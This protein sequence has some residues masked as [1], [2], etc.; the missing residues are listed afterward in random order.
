MH[1][2]L[3]TVT[4]SLQPL[5]REYH[6]GDNFGY[7]I[8]FKPF[9]EREWRKVTVTNPESGLYIHKD[10]SITPAT[11]FQVKI[12]AFNKM[13]DGPYSSTAVIYSADEGELP[14]TQ[15]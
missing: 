3:L 14:G 1:F 8:A 12:K 7:I 10:D 13:G 5:A 4:L 15:L 11:K 9:D 6:Y 2:I